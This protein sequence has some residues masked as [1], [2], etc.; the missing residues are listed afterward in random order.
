MTK[1]PEMFASISSCESVFFPYGLSSVHMLSLL[2]TA[3][4]TKELLSKL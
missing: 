2:T 3:P 4:L 1:I